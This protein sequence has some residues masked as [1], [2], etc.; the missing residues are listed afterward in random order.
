MSDDEDFVEIICHTCEIS[1]GLTESFSAKREADHTP[2]YCPVGHANAWRK[3]D[4]E[5][6]Q[7]KLAEDET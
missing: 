7:L 3:K 5:V 6:H 1:F 4:A 2:F